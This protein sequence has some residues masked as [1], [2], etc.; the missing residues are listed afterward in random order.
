VS[1]E[2]FQ[3]AQDGLLLLLAPIAPFLSEEVWSRLGREYSIH[4]QPWPEFDPQL[5]ED[6][7]ITL[8]V[9]VN[10]RV[11]DRLQVPAG[12]AQAK[13]L[14]AALQLESVAKWLGGKAPRQSIFVPDRLINLVV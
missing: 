1:E 7:I 13:A 10:G 11:R 6:E 14:E 4:Q 12:I 9:Q 3:E 5:A 2:A 8:V